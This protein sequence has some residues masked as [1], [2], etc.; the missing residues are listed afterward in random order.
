MDEDNDINPENY[1]NFFAL[2]NLCKH[3]EPKQVINI[4]SVEFGKVLKTSQ[5]TASRRINDLEKLGWI[6]RKLEGKAQKI[7]VTKLGADIMLRMYQNLK[8]ILDDI[9]IIGYVQS[10]IGEGGYYVSI[11]GYYDQ[12]QNKLGYNPYKGTL[13]LKLNDANNA[14]LNEKL[15]NNKPITIEGFEDQQRQYGPVDC[16]ECLIY[17]PDKM[18]SKQKAAILKIERTHHKGNIIEI[19]AEDYLRDLLH[20]V[21]DDKIVIEIIKN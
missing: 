3:I 11:K 16:Y 21:D 9:V 18:D 4:S 15:K 12:F 14:L 20:L 10:G 5:Q 6:K 1:A 2:Y 7:V 17:R 19:L 13:N 8:E